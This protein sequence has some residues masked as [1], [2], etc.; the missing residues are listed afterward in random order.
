MFLLL[1][2]STLH[3]KTFYLNVIINKFFKNKG[4]FEFIWIFFLKK[5]AKS[6]SPQLLKK[7]YNKVL[8]SIGLVQS[9]FHNLEK[10]TYLQ[11]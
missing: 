3:S 6:F 4:T 8:F 2:H 11:S 9:V 7:I 1:G 10:K 5:D